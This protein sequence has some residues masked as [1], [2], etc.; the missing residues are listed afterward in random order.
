MA[1]TYY[2]KVKAK[3][4]LTFPEPKATVQYEKPIGPEAPKKVSAGQKLLAYAK[5][6]GS[7]L[8]KY[9][10]AGVKAYHER[11]ET[12]AL[13]RKKAPVVYEDSYGGDMFGG[14]ARKRKHTRPKARK[15]VEDVYYISGI[16]QPRAKKRGKQI[17]RY[18]ESEYYSPPVRR[19]KKR[20]TTT[21]RQTNKSVIGNDFFDPLRF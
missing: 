18:Y 14:A 12:V 2:V 11:Q 7:T 15:T 6:T 3:K 8:S 9:G 16:S 1:S 4:P 10:K 21:R 5:S 17:K 19:V 20:K 13:Q